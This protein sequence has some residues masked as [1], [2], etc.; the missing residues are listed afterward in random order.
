MNEY[1]IEMGP[2]PV[3]NVRLFDR[4]AN[5]ELANGTM[6]V[7][8]AQAVAPPTI[9]AGAPKAIETSGSA[10][11]TLLDAALGGEFARR[12]NASKTQDRWYLDISPSDL[13]ALPW[14]IL[15]WPRAVMG[16]AAPTWVRERHHLS[17][18]Y[19]VNWAAE[20]KYAGPIR[21]L[22]VL[23]SDDTDPDVQPSNE[24]KEIRRGIQAV[25]RTLDLEVTEAIPSD[26]NALHREIKRI[27]P[28]VLHFIGHGE[29]AV[30][31]FQGK[32]TWD[33]ESGDLAALGGLQV[34]GWTP[35][36]VFLNACRTGAG[37]AGLASMAG[38]FLASGAVATIAMQG[39]IKGEAAGLLASNFYTRIASGDP[40]DYALTYARA[41]VGGAFPAREAAYPALTLTTPPQ[42][43]LPRLRSDTDLGD[44]VQRLPYCPYLPKMRA[45]VN[46]VDARRQLCGGTWPPKEDTVKPAPFLVLRGGSGY[47]KTLLSAWLLDLCM[48]AGRTVRY[49]RVQPENASSIDAIELLRRIWGTPEKI[50]G[51]TSPLMCWL[52]LDPKGDIKLQETLD[53]GK[54]TASIFE[55]FRLGLRTAS[56]VAPLVIALD[57]FN[58]CMPPGH[59]RQVWDHL[60]T[61]LGTDQ[62]P[63]VSVVLALTDDDYQDYVKQEN[64]T[65]LAMEEV[66]LATLAPD[67][68]IK[69][70]E[71]YVEYR[72]LQPHPLA[73]ELVRIVKKK[74]QAWGNQPI[75]QMEQR[76]VMIEA[77][78]K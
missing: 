15:R 46:Q 45:F 6:A 54:D 48:R 56:A 26:L 3:S 25:Q 19:Q 38:T 58:S 42:C 75:S 2:G 60:F 13:V 14:E 72:D 5:A 12:L 24:V 29:T 8:D 37:A 74:A 65:A 63:N 53:S 69:A 43:A 64:L 27:R 51:R 17:R 11:F 31:R 22:V 52:N 62:L 39:N 16:G 78:L 9:L 71:D 4:V 55:K 41:M 20:P 36:L 1:V 34:E 21:V 76:V 44:Y 47:G 61:Y 33:W 10:L 23:G 49:V 28:H 67:K 30:L 50:A 7:A 35:R 73:D 40:I 18:V 66:P 68:F 32:P 70:F 57:E 77:A 59:F